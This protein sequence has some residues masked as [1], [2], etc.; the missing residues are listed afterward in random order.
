VKNVLTSILNKW[1]YSWSPGCYNYSL[2][3]H[4]QRHVD[5]IQPTV[6][7]KH[8]PVS[9]ALLKRTGR[10]G[11]P[12]SSNSPKMSGSPVAITPSLTNCSHRIT[13]QCLRALYK[14]DYTPSS[15]GKNTFAIGSLRRLDLFF[16]IFNM[17]LNSWIYTS[18]IFSFRSWYVLQVY[19]ESACLLYVLNHSFQKLFTKSGRGEASNRLHRRR[20]V[21]LSSRVLTLQWQIFFSYCSNN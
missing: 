14:I 1:F 8:R 20:F 19:V 2:P 5:L 12:S 7:F 17:L 13:P 21:I 10:L 18:S 4:L 9:N 3:R 15:T 6:H 16:H 11:Q